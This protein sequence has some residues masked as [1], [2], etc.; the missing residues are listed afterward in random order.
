MVGNIRRLVRFRHGTLSRVL[1]RARRRINMLQHVPLR[2]AVRHHHHLDPMDLCKHQ[3]GPTPKPDHPMR[4]IT[5]T[6]R[7]GP[8]QTRLFGLSQSAALGPGLS[9]MTRLKNANNYRLISRHYATLF[10][11]LEAQRRARIQ[12]TWMTLPR[13]R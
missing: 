13:Q 7:S 5:G 2:S 1:T 3:H 11:N 8:N 9:M 10:G 12:R 6:N 4:G